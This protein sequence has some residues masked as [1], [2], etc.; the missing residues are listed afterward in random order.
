MKESQQRTMYIVNGGKL[1]NLSI[2]HQINDNAK[3][4]DL[5]YKI[6]H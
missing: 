5:C 2:L 4:K 3:P 1:L 6:R